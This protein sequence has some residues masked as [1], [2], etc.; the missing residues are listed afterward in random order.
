MST[1]ELFGHIVIHSRSSFSSGK[2]A[3][4]VTLKF[5]VRLF[6]LNECDNID[7]I[8]EKHWPEFESFQKEV[9]KFLLSKDEFFKFLIAALVMVPD[10]SSANIGK[11]LTMGPYMSQEFDDSKNYPPDACQRLHAWRH[12]H[13]GPDGQI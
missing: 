12:H 3:D 4:E 7:K 2:N 11:F 13:P 6:N 9:G 1:V 10:G 8:V 5:S